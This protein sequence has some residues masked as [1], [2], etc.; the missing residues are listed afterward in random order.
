[1]AQGVKSTGGEVIPVE[2][3]QGAVQLVSLLA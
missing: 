1:M 3:A 2:G